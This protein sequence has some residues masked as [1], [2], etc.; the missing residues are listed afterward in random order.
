VLAVNRVKGAAVL[1]RSQ[2]GAIDL[3]ARLEAENASLRQRVVDLA[4]ELMLL[5]ST[6]V[7]DVEIDPLAAPNSAIGS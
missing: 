4:L 3:L 2:E 6:D 5:R 1:V 7:A